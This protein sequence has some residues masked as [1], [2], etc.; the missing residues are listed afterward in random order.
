M[1]FFNTNYSE[2]KT[3]ELV[4]EGEYEVV[5]T[6]VESKPSS[7]GNPMLKL[8][9]TV[10]TDVDQPAQKRKLFENLVQT[11]KAMF[12]FQ[13]LSKVLGFAEGMGFAT[14]EDYGKAIKFK[15]L[16]IKVKHEDNTYKGE[17]KKQE[18]IQYY[19]DAKVP[20]GGGDVTG[21]PQTDPFNLP[22]DAD[23]PPPTGDVPGFPPPSDI[24]PPWEQ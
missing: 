10:R 4:P 9:L 17:T 2:V 16:R 22:S 23:A 5:I 14:I 11:E 15:A 7:T 6:E 21:G 20:Y 12:K 1:S 24:K 13:Q 18:R 3:F 19:M 8:V